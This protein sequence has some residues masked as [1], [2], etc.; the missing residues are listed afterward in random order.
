MANT[1]YSKLILLFEKMKDQYDIISRDALILEIKRYIGS[2]K[3]TITNA[4]NLIDDLEICKKDERGL[5]KL[6]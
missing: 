6:K 5:Y 3:R 1:T 2:D 4:I